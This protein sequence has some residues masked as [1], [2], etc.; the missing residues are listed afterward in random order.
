V[1]VMR[2][3]RQSSRQSGL[4][5]CGI[6]FSFF[7]ALITAA[8]AQ[9]G[10]VYSTWAKT[11]TDAVLT[12]TASRNVYSAGSIVRTETQIEGDF[13]AIGGRAIVDQ[14]IKG[15]AAL[16][17][18]SVNV[19]APVGDDLRVIGGDVILNSAIGGELFAS[20]GT[21]T[22]AK[23]A[24]VANG[25]SLLAGDV[26]IDGNIEGALKVRAKKITI[27]G[28]IQG[29][30]DLYAEQIEFGPT[31]KLNGN[32]R[33]NKSADFR[34]ND[35]AMI[36]GSITPEDIGALNRRDRGDRDWFRDFDD[37]PSV[38]AMGIRSG[39]FIFTFIALLACATVFLLVFPMFAKRSSERISAS[40][41]RTIAVGLLSFLGVPVLI[42]FLF[43]TLLGIPLGLAIMAIYPILVLMGY[44]VSVFFV[45]QRAQAALS[46]TSQPSFLRTFGFFSLAL[47]LVMLLGRLPF[48][49]PLM[50]FMMAT[51]GAGACVI[52]ILRSR[53]DKSGSTP[54]PTIS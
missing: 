3:L 40:P 14:M 54:V 44:V 43:F 34:K 48:I 2:R 37:G 7:V 41:G 20:G 9:S 31:A 6:C 18:G 42:V 5:V 46:K 12:T 53:A 47:L 52:E 36:N 28:E 22:V 19:L 35:A 1:I 27:N 23:T 8:Q 11:G 38:S 15:D 10:N 33:Y 24:R 49:G 17:A 13:V 39:R 16:V 25:A 45:S 30:G 21:I 51:A 29:D 50:I 26:S 32:L 4:S